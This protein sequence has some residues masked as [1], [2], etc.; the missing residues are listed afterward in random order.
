MLRFTPLFGI[1][2]CLM[3]SSLSAGEIGFPEEFALAKD[4][5]ESLKKLIPGTE[6][7]Y[8][9]HCLHYLNSDQIDKAVA[10]TKPWFERFNQTPRLTEIQTR[11]ALLTYDRNP[12][13][14]LEYF[15]S[16]LGLASIIRKSC[17]AERPISP[18]PSIPNRS[19][20]TRLRHT[21]RCDGIREPTTTKN[22][23][24]IGC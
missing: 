7:Y 17:R 12:K 24:L 14:S 11:H 10:L 16:R 22:R 1:L 6:D 13:A 5:M 18:P 2:S 15:R 20:E 9:F 3:V 23:L 21:P 4:R 19:R 8:Y